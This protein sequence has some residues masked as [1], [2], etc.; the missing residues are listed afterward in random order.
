[1]PSNRT[2][3]LGGVWANGAADPPGAPV[4]G[5]T[6]ADSALSQANIES[7]WPFKTIVDSG[8]FNEFLR[9]MSTLIGLMEAWGILPWCATTVYAAGARALGSD[10]NL[11][12]ALGATTGDDPTTHPALWEDVTVAAHAA[13]FDAH[14][15]VVAAT[16]NRLMLRDSNGRSKVATPVTAADIATKGYVDGLAP[17]GVGQTWQDMILSRARDVVYQ[18]TT[19]QPIMV[20]ITIASSGANGSGGSC[21]VSSVASVGPWVVVG[22]TKNIGASNG[23]GVVSFVVPPG[24]WYYCNYTIGSWAELR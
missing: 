21:F 2:A 6:Y 24:H 18:N 4:V 20:N 22:Y 8:G 12:A 9:R 23:A 13:L 17:L 16:A 19:S 3:V 5:D 1:M 10:G 11:Y 7:A 14:G 15:A